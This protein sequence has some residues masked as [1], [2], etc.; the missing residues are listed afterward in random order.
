MKLSEDDAKELI[1]L[2]EIEGQKVFVSV[3]TE[4]IDKHT[5][6]VFKDSK[7]I[8]NNHTIL[9]SRNSLVSTLINW[10]SE[11]ENRHPR[12][13]VNSRL[14]QYLN[15]IKENTSVLASHVDEYNNSKLKFHWDLGKWGLTALIA[16]GGL[17]LGIL[18]NCSS[19]K[20]DNRLES[21]EALPQIEPVLKRSKDAKNKFEPQER[22]YED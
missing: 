11:Y 22:R 4:Y 6:T 9:I 15:R 5:L 14:W 10:L 8:K 13:L 16:A 17:G 1:R 21:I 12:E 20:L 18:N 2:L 7:K 3:L 19:K